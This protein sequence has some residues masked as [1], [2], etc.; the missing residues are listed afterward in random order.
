MHKALNAINFTHYIRFSVIIIEKINVEALLAFLY[1][2]F[3]DMAEF[4]V[5]EKGT[6]EIIIKKSRFIGECFAVQS[7][8]EA[9]KIISETV[10]KYYDAK[11]HCYAYVINDKNIEKASDDGEPS[12]TAGKQIL[13]NIHEK[14]LCNALVIVTRYFGGILLGTGGLCEAYRDASL[15]AINN[16]LISEVMEGYEYTLTLSYEDYGK[17]GYFLKQENYF[18]K[19]PSFTDKVVID[20]MVETPRVE[21]FEKGIMNISSGK[22]ALSKSDEMKYY[23]YKNDIKIF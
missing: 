7:K 16:S 13:F 19:A 9:E 5:I 11:H 18:Y 1:F 17:T 4:E 2:R 14:N 20:V 12:G 8:E 21:G 3:Y 22:I 6:S 15:S 10:K 23:I